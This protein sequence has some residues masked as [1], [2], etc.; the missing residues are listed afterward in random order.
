LIRIV[1]KIPSEEIEK[2]FGI[3]SP[4]GTNITVEWFLQ[5]EIDDEGRHLRQIQEWMRK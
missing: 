3:R 4:N 1:E 5:Y 2:D